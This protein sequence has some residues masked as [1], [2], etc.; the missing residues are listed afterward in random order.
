MCRKAC[1]FDSC[2]GH[3]NP[4]G[5]DSDGVSLFQPPVAATRSAAI[6]P[7][8]RRTAWGHPPASNRPPLPPTP[9]THPNLL[10]SA[11]TQGKATASPPDIERDCRH[12]VRN[13]ACRDKIACNEQKRPVDRETIQ[14]VSKQGTDEERDPP[15]P[16]TADGIVEILHRKQHEQKPQRSVSIDRPR[17]QK[18]HAVGKHPAECEAAFGPTDRCTEECAAGSFSG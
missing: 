7:I 11:W 12:R 16:L 4:V 5:G 8:G 17:P 6:Q 2:P 14:H 9:Q 18:I 1:R 3:R 10:L 15:H 13:A